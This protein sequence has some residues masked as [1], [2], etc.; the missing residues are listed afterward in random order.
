MAKLGFEPD[1]IITFQLLY[2]LHHRINCICRELYVAPQ[3]LSNSSNYMKMSLSLKQVCIPVGCVLTAVISLEGGVY[4]PEADIPY[5]TTLCG[6]TDVCENITFASRS[7]KNVEYLRL[8]GINALCLRRNGKQ[9]TSVSSVG[10]KR[11]GGAGS[12]GD[13]FGVGI[14]MGFEECSVGSEC[15]QVFGTVSSV[16]DKLTE[17]E[18]GANNFES[19]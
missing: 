14:S 12:F 10:D 17:F 8:K 2:Q 18:E 4:T 15:T 16:V 19:T 6:K 3:V 7:I 9:D 5:T 11:G 1:K 13:V